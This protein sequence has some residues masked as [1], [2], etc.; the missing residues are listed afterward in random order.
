MF[1]LFL[2]SGR[3]LEMRA[4]HRAA[5][6]PTRSRA[7]PGVRR[8]RRGGRIPRARSAR[9][10]CGP[11]TASSSRTASR[12]RP[13][14]CSTARTCRIDESWLSGESAP[15]PKRRGD[16][17]RAGTHVV[18][19]PATVR[20]TRVG[21]DTA[22]AALVALTERAAATRPRL[23]LEGD[24]AAAALVAR[25]LLLAVLTALGWALVDPARAF[26]ATVAVLVVACPCAFALAAPAAVH[27]HAR[28]ARAA[29]RAGRE[30]RRARALATATCVVFDKTGTLT[31]RAHRDRP[32]ADAARMDRD[33][34]VAIAAALAQGS[35]HALAR[36]FALERPRA[37]PVTTERE[38]IAGRGIGGVIDGRRYRSAAQTSRCRGS[39]HRPISTTPSSSPTTTARSRPSP[40]T[41]AF[42]RA[43]APR[44]TRWLATA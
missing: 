2:L 32:D 40:S 17:V 14:A 44:S 15:V 5:S 43:R 12:Y 36:A 20:V 25:V 22:V 4:R 28:G 10:N 33:E 31:E 13:T 1:V 9:S 39:A 11:A 21:G 37:L 26:S 30:A 42:G 35:R 24:R 7:D 6:F 3:Y 16:P 27:A 8:P 41:R 18:G 29:R 38:S 34:A 23:A 19:A